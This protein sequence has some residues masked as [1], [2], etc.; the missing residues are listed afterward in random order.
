MHIRKGRD[1]EELRLS[2]SCVVDLHS[3]RHEAIHKSASFASR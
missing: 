1:I 2:G 3:K